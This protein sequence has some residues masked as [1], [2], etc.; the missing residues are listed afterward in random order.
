MSICVCTPYVCL[1][2]IGA[3]NEEVRAPGLQ[4]RMVG[5]HYTGAG[6]GIW[7]LCKND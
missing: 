2:H 4:L 7:V 1:V 3:R 6:K 5:C